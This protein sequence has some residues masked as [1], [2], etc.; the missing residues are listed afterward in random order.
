MLLSVHKEVEELIKQLNLDCSV[1]EFKDKVNWLYISRHQPFSEE[2]IK[3]FH[4]KVDWW[5]I[6]VYQP[7]SEKFIREFK[8]KV[9]WE[10]IS[11]RQK[12]SEEFIREFQ[13]KVHWK[14]IS[15]YQKL[16]E[17]FIKEFQDKVDWSSVSSYQKLSEEFIREFQ[18]KVKW[19]EISIYQ[20]LSEEFIK[21]FQDKVD[22]H[23]YKAVHQVISHQKKLKQ[24]KAY[25]KKYKLQCDNKYLYA[26]RMHDFNGAG[27]WNKAI[28][29]KK[30][31]Y[32]RD[33]H[34]DMRPEVENSFGLGI[35]PEG[36]TKVKVKI[37]DWGVEVFDD[38]RNKVR[39]WGFEI[40]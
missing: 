10:Y 14:E 36:N 3:E 30:G 39:V 27:I 29:Y 37:E 17:E 12:L 2:F 9:E 24:A 23:L 1:E 34:L 22:S 16:S 26:Y 8:D 32:Y 35:F 38:S 20:Q 5:Y 21:E 7:L 13:D 33:W 15:G 25:A 19:K 31:T 28:K 4:D 6:S 11:I 40:V 18:D